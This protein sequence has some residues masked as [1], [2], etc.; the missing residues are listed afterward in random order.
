[1]KQNKFI[2]SNSFSALN[3]EEKDDEVENVYD[4]SANLFKTGG[5]SSFTAADG[6]GIKALHSC[7]K[8]IKIRSID[9]KIFGRDG[10]P[11]MDVHKVQFGT[12]KNSSS[13]RV[14]QPT[15]NDDV[16]GLSLIGSQIRKLIMLDAFTSFVCVDPWG[17][18][19][20]ARALIEV[21]AEADLKH[22][23][24]MAVP[25]EDGMGCTKERIK[26]EYE[27]KPPL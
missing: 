23:V 21:S 8:A 17:R 12:E 25:Y 14:E 6:E 26:V 2:T 3:D 19:G 27:W 4:E 22:E 13:V 5:S 15:S 9:G 11:M 1:K 20:F 10:K 24:I 16:D 7:L 18:I